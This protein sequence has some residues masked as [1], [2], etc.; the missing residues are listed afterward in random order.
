MRPPHKLHLKREREKLGWSQERLAAE[1]G[2]SKHTVSRWERGISLPYPYYREK[3]SMLFGKS[4]S[5]LGFGPVEATEAPLPEPEEQADS[6]A[7]VPKSQREKLE[8]PLLPT[9]AV[10]TTGLVGREGVLARLRQRLSEAGSAVRVALHGLPGVGKTALAVALATDKQVQAEFPDGVLW[11]GLGPR[12]Y[13]PGILARWGTLLG[14]SS[15][16]QEKQRSLTDWAMMLRTAIGSRRILLIIDDAWHEEEAWSLLVGGPQCAYVL[17]TRIPQLAY[18]WAGQEAIEVPELDEAAGIE[19]LARFLPAFV[20]Q[21]RGMA[22]TLVQVVG[23]L[24]LALTL[25]GKYLGAQAYSRQPRRLRA[26]LERLQQSEQRVRLSFSAA[27]LGYAAQQEQAQSLSLQS[28]IAVSDHYLNQQAR[29]GLRSLGVF[30]ARPA[31]FSE[32]A[33]LAV[34]GTSV[35]VLDTLCDVGL[36]ESSGAGRYTLHQTITDYARVNRADDGALRR[37]VAYTVPFIEEQRKAYDVLEREE[38][39]ITS[40]L[41]A[42]C[43]TGMQTELL[44]GVIAMTDFWQVRGLYERARDHLLRAQHVA[45]AQADVERLVMILRYLGNITMSQGDYEQAKAYCQEGLALARQHEYLERVC[46]V[47]ATLGSIEDAQGHY[48]QA[49]R[50]CQEGLALARELNHREQMCLLLGSLGFV[51][52]NRGD[53]LLAQ[54]YYQEGLALARELDLR[55]QICLLL[56]NLG[57]TTIN[58]GDNKRGETYCQEGLVVARELGHRELM[59]RLLNNLGVLYSNSGN[60]IQAESYYRESLDVS[61]RMGY[62]LGV[63]ILSNNLATI[64]I[65]RG[66][67]REAMAY[68]EEGLVLARQMG[69]RELIVNILAGMGEVAVLQGEDEQAEHS[70][71]EGLVLAQEMGHRLLMSYCL[72]GLGEMG[73]LRGAYEQAEIYCQEGLVIARHVDSHENI[74]RSLTALGQILGARGNLYSA[75]AAFQESLDLARRIGY[76]RLIVGSL[77]ARGE[78]LLRFRR[79]DAAAQ[80]FHDALSSIP[81][82]QQD[83]LATARYGLA[84]VAAMQGNYEEAQMLAEAGLRIFVEIGHRLAGEVGQWLQTLALP[85]LRRVERNNLY[86]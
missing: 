45:R 28:V 31:S 76:P 55:E 63:I 86:Y 50:Y 25:M 9:I 64:A 12:P 1:I 16:H 71:Q 60:N 23:G 7:V 66:N 77:L 47:L 67:Y 54:S 52:A 13:V 84:R 39:M 8:D 57:A 24:P 46:S 53:N 80:A 48:E 68:F 61:R 43:S 51:A 4:A 6:I 20:A 58:Q 35:E 27:A 79:W 83:M 49:A 19:L 3:L 41:E 32:D 40:T 36:V 72:V 73:I 70:Y 15:P 21:E 69:H 5:E 26:A 30:P 65:D 75:L 62:P 34:M 17:T 85:P 10:S 74:S 11:A 37:L 56:T 38:G 78:V 59:S 14:V 22:S 82:Q 29:E 42:A 18:A 81:E 2:T 33:A 44:R